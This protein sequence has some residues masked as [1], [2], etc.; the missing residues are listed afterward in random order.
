MPSFRNLNA[1]ELYIKNEIYKSLE[2]DVAKEVVDTMKD[3]INEDVYNAYSPTLY[4][5][6]K[7][8]GGLLD[9]A[10]FLT[11]MVD[12]NTLKV[13]N[14]TH[15]SGKYIVPIIEE[16]VGY[17]WENSN[18]YGRQPFPRPFVANTREELRGEKLRLA[19]SKAL[20]K[21]FGTKSIG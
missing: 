2:D 16:G 20:Q 8:N 19:I 15:G 3:R 11:E 4:E 10:N 9:D 7:E 1:L 17:T 21:R 14:V 18:I 13:K 5:R 6:R 12:D